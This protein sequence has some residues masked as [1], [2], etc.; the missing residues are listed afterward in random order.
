MRERTTNASILYA[1]R[2]LARRAGVAA[3]DIAVWR[4][5]I[6]P[7]SVTIFPDPAR[8]ARI[9]VPFDAGKPA[10]FDDLRERT[11]GIYGWM[12]TAPATIPNLLV[13]FD[14]GPASGQLFVQRDAA[15]IECRT[16]VF[17]PALWAL[18]RFEE[19]QPIERDRHGRV[20]ATSS[21]AYRFGYLERPIVDELGLALGE[22]LDALLPSRQ[23]GVRTLRVKLSH[24][25]D[26]LGIPARFRT[27]LKALSLQRDLRSFTRDAL[28]LAGV[29]RPAYLESVYETARISR[30]R[31]MHSAFYWTASTHASEWD[32]G[33]DVR[34]PQIAE[35]IQTL[36]ADGFEMGLHPAHHT[37]DSQERL[38]AEVAA[39]RRFVGS[40]PIGGRHHYLR[41]RPDTWLAWERAGLA[42]D[43][44]VGYHDGIGFRA[45][46]CVPYHPWLLNDDRESALLE[47]P[48]VVM[49]CTPVSYMAL[50]QPDTLARVDALVRRCEAVGGVFTLLWHNASVVDP[51]YAKLYPRILD[52][53]TRGAQYEWTQDRAIAPLPR[54]MGRGL[55]RAT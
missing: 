46:T 34:H 40:D 7:A 13:P 36:R 49:D 31:G 20:S 19:L 32:R 15:T 39:L 33:Y 16:D 41:W 54:A 21:H 29:G 43:S 24:D 38:D 1:V 45:G 14:D 8:D 9:V 10:R 42:Y 11:P 52:R 47:I 50:P 2:E 27:T 37:F 23:A 18:A 12:R 53:I 4:V 55:H 22:A 48:L 30:V 17:T 35:T 44:T 28:A 25:M 3:R 51:P 26:Q 5:E 6:E